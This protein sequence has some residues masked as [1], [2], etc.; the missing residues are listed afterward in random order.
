LDANE[1]PEKIAWTAAFLQILGVTSKRGTQDALQMDMVAVCKTM[2]EQTLS[3]NPLENPYCAANVSVEASSPAGL[4]PGPEFI[5]YLKA[6]K[7]YEGAEIPRP[8]KVIATLR[9]KAQG[10]L[11]HYE[12]HPKLI[13]KQ[14]QN[15]RKKM[16]CENTLA[17]LRKYE[18]RDQVQALGNPPWDSPKSMQAAS[19]KAQADFVSMDNVPAEVLGGNHV[20]P[21]FW[22]KR[23]DEDGRQEK[24][25]LF[26]PKSTH[27]G[28]GVP[29]GGET[30]R[31]A[32]AGRLGDC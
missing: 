5:A 12:G 3:A 26:K 32:A 4:K 11:D 7:D 16:L 20:F 21:A 29:Q 10:Y 1:T 9:A 6:L 24:T 30:A 23:A 15:L 13:Q 28:D 19:L 25:F 8:S 27:S 14:P 31:E 18:L 22:V 2:E 17:E